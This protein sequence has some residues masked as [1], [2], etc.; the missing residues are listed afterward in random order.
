MLFLDHPI[1]VAA[2]LM[3]SGMAIAPTM[4]SVLGVVQAGVP[5]GRLT[6]ALAWNSTGIAT[7]LAIG[8]AA[9]GQVIDL[10]G[11][12]AGFVG[13]AVAGALLILAAQFVRG[14]GRAGPPV[15]QLLRYSRQ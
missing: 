15:R 6:E 3:I 4:I 10:Q 8:V 9:L 11:W 14:V 5:A 13:V 2:A 1:L 7:G 12:R